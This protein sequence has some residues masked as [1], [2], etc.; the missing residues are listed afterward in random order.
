MLKDISSSNYCDLFQYEFAYNLYEQ[1]CLFAKWKAYQSAKPRKKEKTSKVR[2]FEL[3]GRGKGA[4]RD[5][6]LKDVCA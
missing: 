1:V 3:G 5:P 4:E 6:P 2:N